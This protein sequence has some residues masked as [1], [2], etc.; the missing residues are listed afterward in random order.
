MCQICETILKDAY[1]RNIYPEIFPLLQKCDKNNKS[2]GKFLN[3]FL[4]FDIVDFLLQVT[5][6]KESKTF[7]LIKMHF[8]LQL[9]TGIMTLFDKGFQNRFWFFKSITGRALEAAYPM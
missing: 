9:W 5:H 2:N 8:E 6:F 1:V 3:T 4:Y 7:S